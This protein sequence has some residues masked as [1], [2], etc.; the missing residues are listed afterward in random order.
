MEIRGRGGQRLDDAWRDGAK[1]W[2]GIS[3]PGFPNFFMLYGPNTNLGH[4]SIV[5]MLECQVAHVMR[6]LRRAGDAPGATIEVGRAPFERFNAT[7]QRRSAQTVFAGCT[8]WYVDAQGRHTVNWP[9]FTTTYRWLTR[10]AG[11]GAYTVG[12]AP[13]G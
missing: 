1:A 3:V 13:G 10:R 6:C 8:S 2:L 7:L 12:R 5:F 4:N 9:G 11:L